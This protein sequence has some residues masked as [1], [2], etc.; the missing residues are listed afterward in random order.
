MKRPDGLNMLPF[1]DSIEMFYIARNSNDPP[2]LVRSVS[3]V[4]SL[5]ASDEA[6]VRLR[7]SIADGSTAVV[8]SAPVGYGGSA[9][10]GWWILQNDGSVQDEMQDGMHQ[11][12]EYA[13]RAYNAA[14]SAVRFAAQGAQIECVGL[15]SALMLSG[16]LAAGNPEA[17]SEAAANAGELVVEI[18]E[19]NEKKEMY[20][21]AAECE[22]P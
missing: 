8:P 9:D 4:A 13:Q 20:D 2:K 19:A 15:V 12:A 1:D 16:T 17:F 3:D 7:E 10:Y 22:L 6:K 21:L 18:A 5:N 11:F 14:R